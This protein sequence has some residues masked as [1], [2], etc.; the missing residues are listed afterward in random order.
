MF[1]LPSSVAS[2]FDRPAASVYAVLM[3]LIAVVSLE[4]NFWLH[5]AGPAAS[6]EKTIPVT[7]LQLKRSAAPVIGLVPTS[8]LTAEVGTSVIPDSVRITNSPADLRFTGAGPGPAANALPASA[9]SVIPVMLVY[10]IMSRS[11]HVCTTSRCPVMLTKQDRDAL[12]V[13]FEQ[14]RRLNSTQNSV[15]RGAFQSDLAATC[16][17]LG[18]TKGPHLARLGRRWAT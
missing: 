11:M 15:G 6:T 16:R 7:S 17:M 2:G 13:R 12:T 10:F 4:G 8:P 9:R 5:G 1:P 14:D 3:S 18:R